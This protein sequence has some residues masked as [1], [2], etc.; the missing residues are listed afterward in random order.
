[1][2]LGEHGISLIVRRIGDLHQ[3]TEKDSFGKTIKMPFALLSYFRVDKKRGFSY[4]VI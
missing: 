3:A 2:S 4:C 1:M